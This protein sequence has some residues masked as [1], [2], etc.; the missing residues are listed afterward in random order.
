MGGNASA[1]VNGHG[2]LSLGRALEIAR[3]SESGVD[4]VIGQF[5]E[6]AMQELWATLHHN[7]NYA[8]SGDEL[9]LLTYYQSRFRNSPVVQRAIQQFWDRIQGGSR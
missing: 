1:D 2:Y 9:A 6:K 4:P 8:I 5:L 3:N 7:P